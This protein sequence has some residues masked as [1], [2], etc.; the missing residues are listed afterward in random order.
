MKRLRF[1]LGALALTGL[2]FALAACARSNGATRGNSTPP[3]AS[4]R[5]TVLVTGTVWGN[6]EPCG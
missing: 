3:A 4:G 2:G 5:L 1:L 6:L